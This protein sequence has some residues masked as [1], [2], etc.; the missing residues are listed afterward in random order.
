MRMIAAAQALWSGLPRRQPEGWLYPVYTNSETG[1]GWEKTTEIGAKQAA[2]R[3]HEVSPARK[4][5]VEWEIEPSRGAV[6]RF[7]RR[8]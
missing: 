1:V 5:R 3:R 7:S 4:R 8:R 2:Q 6:A